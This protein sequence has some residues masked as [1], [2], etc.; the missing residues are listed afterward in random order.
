MKVP[1]IQKAISIKYK[2]IVNR[3][4]LDRLSLVTSSNKITEEILIAENN[5]KKV[6][7]VI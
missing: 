3:N 6:P 1:T 4:I 5:K 7:L 2:I